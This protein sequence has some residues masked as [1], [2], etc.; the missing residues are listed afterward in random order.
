MKFDKFLYSENSVSVGVIS[1]ILYI[2]S[3]KAISVC[4]KLFV[5]S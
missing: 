5:F 1:E 2:V 4:S 3:P